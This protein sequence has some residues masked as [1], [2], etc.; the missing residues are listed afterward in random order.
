MPIINITELRSG[1][2]PGQRLIGLDPGTRT[3]GVAISDVTLMLAS[4]HT[5]LRRTRLSSNAAE[6]AA[7]AKAQG[8]GG[9]IVG[10]P[11]SMDG[12]MGPAA[13]AARDW[14]R[15]LSHAVGLPAALWDERLSS[16]AVNRFLISEADMTRKRRA[17]V[18]DQMAAAYMLQAALDASIPNAQTV[19]DAG[20]EPAAPE[21]EPA[22]GLAPE[23]VLDDRAVDTPATAP[24]PA[25]QKMEP[26]RVTAAKI[27]TRGPLQE[28]AIP[29]RNETPIA[30]T[31]RIDAV[32]RTEIVRGLSN[33]LATLEAAQVAAIV[34]G[35][36]RDLARSPG[37]TKT[38][39]VVTSYQ[40]F[41]S[42]Y[43]SKFT[44]VE[45]QVMATLDIAEFADHE[46]WTMLIVASAPGQKAADASS[47]IGRPLYRLRF[48]IDY[49]PSVIALLDI[50]VEVPNM[51]GLQV[52]L[53][54]DGGRRSSPARAVASMDAVIT[55][56]EAF[57]DM[58][59]RPSSDLVLVSCDSGEDKVFQ[60]AGLPDLMDKLRT[61]LLEI[62]RNAIYFRERKFA[63]RLDMTAKALPVLAE[64]AALEKAGTLAKER[65]ELLRRKMLA[66]ATKFIESGSSIPEMNDMSLY[67]PREVLA[68][69]EALLLG[70]A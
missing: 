21:P 38:L 6:I 61:T 50:P 56:Y 68:P 60:Y 66:G 62:W 23:S 14:A 17:G 57:A 31:A 9:L 5:A 53:P 28:P 24:P 45:R 11:L 12:S 33:L 47:A 8:A 15:A 70:G 34:E 7:I 59:G 69:K 43:T 51:A 25:E 42:A 20:P 58:T 10:L 16:A 63:E 29:A 36:Y 48:I 13:Q 52:V 67:V 35:V 65:A 41:M 64:L 49:L 22:P 3:I 1:L 2:R 32:L 37:E 39:D 44:H 26:A 46:W 40:A 18:V 19:P 54:E 4:P 30:H 55:L 27:E